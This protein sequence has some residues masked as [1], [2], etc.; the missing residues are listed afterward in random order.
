M[1]PTLS[2]PGT[3]ASASRPSSV[4]GSAVGGTTTLVL[5]TPRSTTPAHRQLRDEMATRHANRIADLTLVLI[6]FSLW[7]LTTFAYISSFMGFVTGCISTGNY[8]IRQGR[9]ST[10]ARGLAAA[11]CLTGWLIAVCVVNSI[12]FILG[13]FLFGRVGID[14]TYQV[15]HSSDPTS[16][17]RW[18]AY[19]CVFS[20]VVSGIHLGLSATI[21]ILQLQLRLLLGILSAEDLTATAE[22]VERAH[23][24]QTLAN[25]QRTS[26][27]GGNNATVIAEVMEEEK[28]AAEAAAAAIEASMAAS[29]NHTN[30]DHY[31]HHRRSQHRSH[32]HQHHNNHRQE[33]DGVAMGDNG[34]SESEIIVVENQLASAASATEKST[35]TTAAGMRARMGISV[36]AEEAEEEGA[37]APHPTPYAAPG[38]ATSTPV[39]PRQMRVAAMN[40]SGSPAAT[41]AESGELTRPSSYKIL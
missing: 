32:S 9:D 10:N 35:A 39:S 41:T 2:I 18:I 12:E 25:L 11:T 1:R 27:Y 15:D 16:G 7:G 5:E 22:F 20:W 6:F 17:E 37:I 13:M 21:L 36:P 28:E 38:G 24:A 3:W 33:F 23:H 40:G 31:H 19:S 8:S 30:N 4:G 26:M 34:S 14:Y 29:S